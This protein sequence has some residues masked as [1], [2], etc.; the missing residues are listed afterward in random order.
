MGGEQFHQ[1]C[2]TFLGD[3]ADRRPLNKK[4]GAAARQKGHNLTGLNT[5]D[6]Y[7]VRAHGKYRRASG[8]AKFT[9]VLRSTAENCPPDPRAGGGLC[10]LRK[11]S[12]SQGLDDDPVGPLRSLRLDGF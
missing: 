5:S 6:F 1:S 12:G 7:L 3:R 9:S 2:V 11:S 4:D 8:F 10:G